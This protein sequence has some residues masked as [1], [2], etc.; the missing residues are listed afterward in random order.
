MFY[1]NNNMYRATINRHSKRVYDYNKRTRVIKVQCKAC[2]DITS[3]TA[4]VEEKAR[5]IDAMKG[6]QITMNAPINVLSEASDY[7]I[8]VTYY[9]S[10]KICGYC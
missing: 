6:I 4:V 8:S 5:L 3:E 10:P 9:K 2:G 7:K 1:N